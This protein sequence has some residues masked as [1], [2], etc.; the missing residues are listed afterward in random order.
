MN[1]TSSTVNYQRWL[2][3]VQR[4]VEQNSCTIG[5]LLRRILRIFPQFSG[6]SV[7][8]CDNDERFSNISREFAPGRSIDSPLVPVMFYQ[9][10]PDYFAALKGVEVLRLQPATH[11]S[12]LNKLIDLKYRP[13]AAVEGLDLPIRCGGELLGLLTVDVD[14][15]SLVD[16]D[17][18]HT[19]RQTASL[20]A[21]LMEHDRR[22][23][24]EAIA[25]QQLLESRQLLDSIVEGVITVDAE[26]LIVDSN[27]AAEQILG[28]LPGE[29]LHRS[30]SEIT[31]ALSR[32]TSADRF[33][34][35]LQA[36]G[37]AIS[38][39]TTEQIAQAKDG[40]QI[41]IR[42]S[43][44]TLPDAGEGADRY[45]GSFLDISS[46]K[47]QQERLRRTQ[48]ME[49]LG[50]LTGGIAHDFN[51]MLG[52]V[53]GYAELVRQEALEKGDKNLVSRAEKIT[54]AGRRGSELVRRLLAAARRSP[55][56]ARAVNL[57]ELL[58]H[59]EE[60]L[61]K[62]LTVRI[63]LTLDCADELWITSVDPGEF[64]DVILNLAVNAM[65]AIDQR[66]SLQFQTR[67]IELQRSEA[68]TLGLAAGDY[69]LVSAV[70]SGK[71]MGEQTLDRAFEPF[72][73]TRPGEGTGLGLSQVYGMVSG[74][75]GAVD[76][77]SVKGRGTRVDLY[78][79]RAKREQV[80]AGDALSSGQWPQLK[81]PGGNI[82]V[83]D[84]EPVLRELEETVLGAAGYQVI[85]AG[86]GKDALHLLE[87]ETVDMVLSDIIMPEMD[88]YELAEY[89]AINRPDLPVRLITGYEDKREVEPYLTELIALRKP[90]KGRE[91]VELVDTT[92]LPG[93]E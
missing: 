81:R 11:T 31:P 16:A 60:L 74:A 67:N 68:E 51:N 29:L 41:P 39:S 6:C 62:T 88:G 12:L 33:L 79:P 42:L 64:E 4:Q 73:S 78:F 70:D 72:F 43:I 90:F 48:A 2:A 92:L 19:L 44:A 85:T 30:V 65:H 25:G 45:V 66:G 55:G 47:A 82:L 23:Q 18:E 35:E 80:E 22:H 77:R 15:G 63:D 3:D 38:D 91:L 10:C 75:G 87:T 93:V 27:R 58:L 1:R 28:F 69:I 32:T 53:L 52:V 17:V 9:N 89:L 24:V 59:S 20:L 71:G 56:S 61:R 50:Q 46:E 49:S 8:R 57:N 34:T 76:I 37:A 13:P 26:G 86:N 21:L 7:W 84:D 83:V 14:A 40:R 5:E 36:A 54:H